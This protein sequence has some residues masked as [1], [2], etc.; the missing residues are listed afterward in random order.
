MAKEMTRSPEISG[1]TPFW[2]EQGQGMNAVHCPWKKNL[3]CCGSGR[4]LE[5]LLQE[6]EKKG[7]YLKGM[8]PGLPRLVSPSASFSLAQKCLWN[9]GIS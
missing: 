7:M 3:L 6:E 1:M 2:V 5:R 8:T 4:A 9:W